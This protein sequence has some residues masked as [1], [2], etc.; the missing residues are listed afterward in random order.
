MSL[1]KLNVFLVNLIF[2]IILDFQEN[3][4]NSIES[5]YIP[6]IPVFLIVNIFYEFGSFVTINK[7]IQIHYQ[8]PKTIFDFLE[9]I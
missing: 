4:E 9:K 7:P 1:L 5:F 2:K 3:Y 8:Q 6:L